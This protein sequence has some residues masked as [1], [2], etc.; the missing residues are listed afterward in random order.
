MFK[1]AITGHRPERI[2]DCEKDIQNWLIEQIKNL[3]GYYDDVVLISGMARG[4]D[5]MAA[6]AALKCGAAVSC[7][8]SY[9][10]KLSE[11]QAYITDNAKEVRYICEKYQDECFLKRDC[12]IVDDCDLL[13]VVWDG[14][15]NG[16]A[17]LTYQYALNKKK[18]MLIFPWE[19]RKN[20][21]QEV[22]CDELD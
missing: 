13:L 17:Y 16:G 11:G 2:K 7:Y 18:N 4:V 5:Q 12:R 1:V 22:E 14:N 3:Q 20:L 21:E 8:F 6:L 15:K 10:H 9:R 19:E